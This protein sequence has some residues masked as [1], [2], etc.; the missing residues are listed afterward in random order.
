M[1]ELIRVCAIALV[2][3]IAVAILRKSVP[4]MSI[5]LT[6]ALISA[7]VFVASG[8]L[9]SVIKFI[10]ELAG[11]AGIDREL[12]SPLLRCVG[13]SIVS[14]MGCD[15]CRDAGVSAAAS[16]IELVGGAASIMCASP[17]MVAVLR[18]IGM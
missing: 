4:E 8:V 18:Q 17:L 7:M 16:Y 12:L 2:G 13:I 14:R 11:G 1:E 3:V 9:V 15:V 6:L 5:V 10:Y